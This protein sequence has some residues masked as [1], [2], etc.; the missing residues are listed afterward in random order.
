MKRIVAFITTSAILL[1]LAACGAQ[2]SEQGVQPAGAPETTAENTDV[3]TVSEMMTETAADTA[4]DEGQDSTR[5]AAQFNLETRT[6]LLNNGMEMPILGLG[7]YALTPEQAENS[8][9]HAL[10]DGYRLIDTANAYMNERGVGRGIQR[11]IDEGI[12]TREDVFLTTKLW[13]SEYE[14]VAES[15][16]ETL[17]RLNLD[18]IDLLLLHQ[19]YGSYAEAYP[20]LEQAV[21]DGKVRAIGLSNFY[22]DRFEE[23]MSVATIPPAVLQV[24]TNPLNQ[25]IDTKEFIAEYGTRIEAWSPL[26]GRGNTD[27]LFN[28]ETIAE[29]AEAH[30]KSVVQVILRWHMQTG[31]IA[32]PGSTNPDHIQENIE[33]FDF[34]LTSEEMEQINALD[35]GVGVYDF[36]PEAVEANDAAMTSGERRD[37]DAQE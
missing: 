4:A 19:P 12:V 36:S 3:E 24:E 11:A 21:K 29:I 1:S 18:Y 15:I 33:I 7:T 10:Q 30:H 14:R 25:Q 31:N 6:V 8:V 27:D 35:T 20:Q 28:N 16:D 23:V 22:G 2:P 32:I 9:Y 37:F 17:A 34:E 13:V 26:G 5:E